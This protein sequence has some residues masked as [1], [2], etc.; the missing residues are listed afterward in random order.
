MAHDAKDNEMKTVN[1]QITDAITQ[2]NMIATGMAPANSMGIVYQTLAQSTGTSLQN[3]VSNQQNVNSMSL[4]ALSQNIQM[5][6]TRPA[7]QT[8]THTVQPIIIQQAPPPKR[9]K[10]DTVSED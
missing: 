9:Q 6:L 7:S 8:V 3:A 5:I 2:S 1:N 4:A 10:G